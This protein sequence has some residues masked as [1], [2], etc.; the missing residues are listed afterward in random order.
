MVTAYP[1]KRRATEEL[2]PT[3]LKNNLVLYTSTDHGEWSSP[4]SV[5]P[6]SLLVPH[7][8]SVLLLSL[9]NTACSLKS[10]PPSSLSAAAPR[11]YLYPVLSNSNPTS[12][13]SHTCSFGAASLNL[14]STCL[15]PS[16]TQLS[17]LVLIGLVFNCTALLP[18]PTVA[19]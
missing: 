14:D 10:V 8:L 2:N 16:N 11:Q 3:T 19:I 1:P 5:H 7:P 17:A 15:R 18:Q 9:T 4:A 6:F 12:E 13:T